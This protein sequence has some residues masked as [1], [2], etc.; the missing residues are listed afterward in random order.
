MKT[1][2]VIPVQWQC[3]ALRVALTLSALPQLGGKACPGVKHKQ[4]AFLTPYVPPAFSGND[5]FIENNKR[6]F[7]PLNTMFGIYDSVS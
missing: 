6:F 2:S 7:V 5:M 1:S 4:I 3:Y